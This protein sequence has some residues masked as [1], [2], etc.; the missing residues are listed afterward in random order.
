MI[1][2]KLNPGIPLRGL[3]HCKV[4]GR[5]LTG[6]MATGRFGK[7][8]A[9]YFCSSKCVK[10]SGIKVEKEIERILSNADF[11]TSPLSHLRA[12]AS[13]YL[14]NDIDTGRTARDAAQRNVA[15]L[16]KRLDKLTDGW[17][18]GVVDEATYKSQA[19]VIRQQITN[20]QEILNAE[21][22]DVNQFTRIL[23]RV[24]TI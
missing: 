5:M 21:T 20:Q 8:Y 9:H 18:T 1:I 13:D 14:K 10:I 22:F 19:A 3:I 23:G 11:L 2:Q 16:N 12:R 4:C 6:G 7:K 15:H 17:L 24:D